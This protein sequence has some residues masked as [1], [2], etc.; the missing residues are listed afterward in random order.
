MVAF[1]IDPGIAGRVPFALDELS[2]PVAEPPGTLPLG[3]RLGLDRKS[4]DL[5]AIPPAADRPPGKYLAKNG[6][7]VY[8]ARGVKKLDAPKASL[9][10]LDH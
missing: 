9:F 4:Y 2:P 10:A 3:T 8:R 7:L 5:V 6:K 1:V